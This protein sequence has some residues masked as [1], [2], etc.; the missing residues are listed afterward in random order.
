ME[1]LNRMAL[2][3]VDEAIDFASELHVGVEEL[4]GGAT[5]LDFGLDHPGGHEAGL[6]LAKIQS[7]GLASTDTH[8][9]SFDGRPRTHVE[10]STDHPAVALLCSAAASW[11]LS[12]DGFEG[13][14]S[15]PARALVAAEGIYDRVGYRDTAEFAVLTVETD[16]RPTPA[17]AAEVADACGVPTES[18]FLVAYP[19]A[20]VAGAVA[21]AARTAE[22][23]AV[24]LTE[25]GYDPVDLLTVT[26]QAPIPPVPADE[27]TAMARG[28]DATAHAGR[29]HLTVAE[30][31]D[32]IDGIVSTASEPFATHYEEADDGD[33]SVLDPALF[34]PAV[35]TVDVVGG[36]TVA[37]GERRPSIA[38]TGFGL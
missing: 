29:A 6:L 1:S 14:G 3:L 37:V 24:R 33:D 30:P 5:V 7:A 16:E 21:T 27:R 35:A 11:Q 25:L 22:L 31:F 20:S 2:E 13:L 38:A 15:G 10:T 36:G 23:S 4:D 32:R 26:G 9:E 8:I 34:G 19:S 28:S 12:V 17:V 18:V